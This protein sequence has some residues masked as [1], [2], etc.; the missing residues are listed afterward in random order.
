[1]GVTYEGEF[2][3][4]KRHGQETWEH[5]NGGKY[6]GEY[7]NGWWDVEKI[8]QGPLLRKTHIHQQTLL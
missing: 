4:G 1:M 7:K 6:V 8:Q 2:K 5:P 3:N